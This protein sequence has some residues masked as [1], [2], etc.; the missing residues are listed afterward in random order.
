LDLL[1]VGNNPTA[2][3]GALAYHAGDAIRQRR[4]KS[5]GLLA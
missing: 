2:T 3:V 4:L 5:P 1:S